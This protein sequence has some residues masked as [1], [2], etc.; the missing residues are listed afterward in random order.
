M[1]RSIFFLIICLVTILSVMA[2]TITLPTSSGLTT[3]GSGKVTTETRNVSG[4]ERVALSGTGDLTITQGD[5]EGLEIEAEDNLITLIESEVRGGTLYIG[6]KNNTG[7]ISPTKPIIYRLKVKQLSGIEASGA[8]SIKVDS[9]AT[10]DLKLESSGAGNITIG[11]L[12]AKQITLHVSGAGNCELAGKADGLV[13]D[14]SG[15]G[16]IRAGDLET[17]TVKITI[18]GA[19]KAVVWATVSLDAELSGAG[20]VEYYGKPS[21]NVKSSGTGQT[22][23]LGDK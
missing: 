22:K 23:S 2:C 3:R 19:G 17:Q 6:F 12:T 11:S 16:A 5:S 1:K 10:D 21:V 8:G 18:S 20:N 7:G 15:A 4:F 14:L 13:V 9:L